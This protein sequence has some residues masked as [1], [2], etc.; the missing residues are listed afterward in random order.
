MAAAALPLPDPHFLDRHAI[1]LH[2]LFTEYFY[3]GHYHLA[4][5]RRVAGR[6]LLTWLDECAQGPAP[7]PPLKLALLTALLLTVIT[8]VDII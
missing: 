2:R 4:T 5:A 1:R 8:G 3:G 6:S 7:C